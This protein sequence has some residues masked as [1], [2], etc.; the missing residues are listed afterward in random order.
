MRE[1]AGKEENILTGDH[2]CAIHTNPI[3]GAPPLSF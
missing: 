2:H 1:R 3:S